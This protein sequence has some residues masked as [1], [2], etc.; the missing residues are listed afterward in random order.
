MEPYD[1]EDNVQIKYWVTHGEEANAIRTGTE[2]RCQNSPDIS[3]HHIILLSESTGGR[4][5]LQAGERL[6]AC[7]YALASRDRLI[8]QEDIRNFCKAELG[9][10]LKEVRFTKGLAPSPHPKQGYIRTLDIHLVP[11]NFGDFSQTEWDHIAQSLFIKIKNLS[12]D[13]NNF[14]IMLDYEAA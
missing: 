6:E 8:T 10:K 13:G 14:R 4:E 9:K 7:R 11:F 2:F 5:Q 3:N 12:P 1:P